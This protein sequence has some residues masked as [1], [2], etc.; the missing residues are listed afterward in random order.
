MQG[1]SIFRKQSGLIGVPRSP[2]S[3][4]GP[5]ELRHALIDP[6]IRHLGSRTRLSGG[7]SS[8]I[9]QKKREEKKKNHGIKMEDEGWQR[10][11]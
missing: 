2:K 1:L 7:V 6:F 5:S 9:R 4:A 10:K 3:A 8:R 11:Q